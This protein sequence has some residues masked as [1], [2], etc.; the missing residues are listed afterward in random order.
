M[1]EKKIDRKKLEIII[2]T[3]ATILIA[4][5]SVTYGFFQDQIGAPTNA[6]VNIGTGTPDDLRFNVSK[7]ISIN[8]NQF[9]F[10][11]GAGNR[12]DSAVA[13]ASLIANST[14]NT[15]TY[16]YYVYFRINT[17]EYIYTTT[18]NKP[19]IILT[20]TDPN[21]NP[22][23]AIDGLTYVQN[24]QTTTSSGTTQTVSGFDITTAT[25][26]FAVAS[27]YT[28]TSN[29][30]TSATTQN[31]NFTATFINLE[32]D[33]ADNTGK[34]LDAEILIQQNE[35]QTLADYVISQYTG[36]DG[37]NGLYYHD[38]D[39][40][41]GAG[42]NSYRYAG[43]NPNNYVCFGSS[44]ATCPS[45]NLYRIIGVFGNEVKL[46]K[47]TSYGSYAWNSGNSN[48]WEPNSETYPDI[49]TTLKSTFLETLNATWQ[50]KIATHAYK[51][52]GMAR[53]NSATAKQYYET[54]I[55]SS[56]SSTT[57]SAK[58]GLM[59][60]SDYGFAASPDYWTTELYNYQP[61]KSSNWMN[62]SLTD[63]TISRTSDLLASAFRVDS[64]GYV[65]HRP[66]N[67]SLGV[68]PVFYLT[69]STTYVSG[70]GSSADP[71]RVS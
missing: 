61:S 67:Y 2:I 56:S 35:L 64:A 57:Y 58:I 40:A 66:V 34:T 7:D 12:S 17:N 54:E 36:T 62:I 6:N 41:N 49:R 1:E 11:V 60:V 16:T 22:V 47:S 51:V 28:I 63:W 59:Y 15:A 4:I 55:G 42:D 26:T 24:V 9:N 3:V 43:A 20:V 19:E 70:S 65:Y 46:I 5:F 32:T 29:S 38:A 18:D 68:R 48:T 21:G 31:W 27:N 45:A 33:Q 52:G 13:I 23:T 53:N 39:L 30:S 44:A 25:G 8:V 37:E 10:G 14:Y 71:I 50:N 69:S